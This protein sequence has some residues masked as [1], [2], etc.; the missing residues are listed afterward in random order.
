M[1]SNGVCEPGTS[2]D[3]VFLQIV[4]EIR[5]SGSHISG[6]GVPGSDDAFGGHCGF[7]PIGLIP[8]YKPRFSTNH[9]LVI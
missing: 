3:L 6:S 8:S 5:V 1:R 7:N 4:G 9:L 2:E